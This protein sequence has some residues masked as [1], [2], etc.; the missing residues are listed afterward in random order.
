MNRAQ[1]GFAGALLA[2]AL[3]LPFGNA[4]A[5]QSNDRGNSSSTRAVGALALPVSGSVVGGGVFD[6]TLTINRF[7]RENGQLVAIGFV[8]GTITNAAGAV[9]QTGM[10]T[11]TLPVTVSSGVANSASWAVEPGLVPAAWGGGNG[12]R[13]MTVQS[14][15]I[16]HLELGPLELNLL[17]LTVNLNRVVLDI[18]GAPGLLGQLICQ[19]LGILGTGEI[20]GLLN[21]ILALLTGL[22]G[23]L[24]A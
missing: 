14:C 12:G 15:G 23:G 2:L 13:W 22:L 7:A 4:M 8:R 16:L 3:F 9:L 11:V 18:G 6:G 21:A 10:R 17:G 20:L 19:L 24:G 5:D 1:Y